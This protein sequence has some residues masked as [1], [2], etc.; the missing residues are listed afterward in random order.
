MKKILLTSILSIVMCTSLIVGATVAL[1][2]SESNVNISVNSG[3]VDVVATIDETNVWTKQHNQD[4]QPGLD[5]TY[6]QGV[7]IDSQTGTVTLDKFVP[8]DGVKFNINIENKSSV[9]VKYRTKVTYVEGRELFNALDI[10]FDGKQTSWT[11]LE[12]GSETTTVGVTVEFPGDAEGAEGMMTQLVFT[13]EAVQGNAEVPLVVETTDELTA[14]L[15]NESVNKIELTA[16]DFDVSNVW[17]LDGYG[18][19][20]SRPLT[21][22]GAGDATVLQFGDNG[23]GISSQA[24]LMISASNVTLQDLAIEA[25]QTTSPGISAIKVTNVNNVAGPYPENVILKN[26]T[27]SAGAGH[28]INV[29][30]AKNVTIDGC[31]LTGYAKCGLAIAN[32]Q[33]ITVQNT[34]FGNENGWGDIGIMYSSTK[35]GFESPSHLILGTGNVFAKNWIYS[36]RPATANGGQDTVQGLENYAHLMQIKSDDYWV[37]TTPAATIG[38]DKYATI[39]AAVDAAEDKYSR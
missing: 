36:E 6:M 22:T 10:T 11:T 1:F 39:Q 30:G 37:I 34:T 32:T 5:G 38:N 17:M 27:I 13:V 7:S 21:I 19:L 20:I 14:A 35:A 12:V 9:T 29:H 8:G 25:G 15:Q 26:V 18:L 2:T 24:E 16:G 23:S 3:N 31:K 4:Y 28:A 33:D